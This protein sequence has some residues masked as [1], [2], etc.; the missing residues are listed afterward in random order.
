MN[1]GYSGRMGLYELLTTNQEMRD[2]ILSTPSM[3]ELRKSLS[4]GL[5]TSLKHN[6]YKMVAEGQ[7]S[8][9]EIDRV[10]GTD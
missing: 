2:V 6:G 9:D 5:F 1:T 3:S 7:T 10:V 4:M 8:L